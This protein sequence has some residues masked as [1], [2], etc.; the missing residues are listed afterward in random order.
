MWGQLLT[1]DC[2]Y[3]PE[4]PTLSKEGDQ[5]G[6]NLQLQLRPEAGVNMVNLEVLVLQNAPCDWCWFLQGVH[7]D[8]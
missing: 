3:E 2:I 7:L 1:C 8:M 6:G 5:H 4:A